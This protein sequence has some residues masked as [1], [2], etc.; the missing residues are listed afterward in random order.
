MFC[1]AALSEDAALAEVAFGHVAFTFEHVAAL[2][3]DAA[4][5][6]IG[7]VLALAR[8]ALED[9]ALDDVAFVLE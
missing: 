5:L 3:E 6:D 8:I 7:F 9:V 4:L 1:C 2:M